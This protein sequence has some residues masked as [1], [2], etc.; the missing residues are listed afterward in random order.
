MSC[1][2]LP[3][4][5]A[6]MKVYPASPDKIVLGL[7]WYAY[8]FRC[9]A[10]TSPTERLCNATA[11]YEGHFS[12]FGALDV[13]AGVNTPKYPNLTV[14]TPMSY[15]PVATSPYFNFRNLTDGSIHQMWYEDPTS[16]AAKYEMADKLH[17]RGVGF[18]CASGAWPD[19]VVGTD[20]EDAAMWASVR[21]HFVKPARGG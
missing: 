13:L 1:A 11:D 7:P 16:L 20:A 6:A 18:Y 14:T 3:Q 19:R 4:I 21:D 10:E 15:D 5:E 12:Y 2:P 17:P 8:D 9:S